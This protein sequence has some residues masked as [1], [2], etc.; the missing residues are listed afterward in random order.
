MKI[1]DSLGCPLCKNTPENLSMHA[2]LDVR[3]YIHC[4]DSFRSGKAWSSTIRSKFLIQKN[5][6]YIL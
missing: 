5:I 4:G 2:F 3:K 6:C 1:V